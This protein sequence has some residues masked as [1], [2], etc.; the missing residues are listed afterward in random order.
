MQTTRRH[1]A[2]LAAATLLAPRVLRAAPPPARGGVRRLADSPELGAAYPGWKPGELDI[3]FIHTGIGENAFY[4]FPDGTRVVNDCGD[5]WRKNILPQTPSGDRLAAEWVARYIRRL[6]G[7]DRRIDYMLVSHWHG[8]HVGDVRQLARRGGVQPRRLPSGRK[9]CGLAFLGDEFAFGQCLDHQHPRDGLYGDAYC[10]DV[11]NTFLESFIREKGVPRVAFRVGA[12][13]QI[14][15]LHDPD[16]R[17]D[18]VFSVRNICANGVLWDGR[19][20]AEDFA[21]VHARVTGAKTL[22]QNQLS[23]AVRIDYGPFSFFTG[24]DVCGRFKDAAGNWINYEELVGRRTGPVDVCKANH[25]ASRDAMCPAF[26]RQVRAS[27]Y[28][29]NVWDPGHGWDAVPGRMTSQAVCPG[30]RLVC[31]TVMTDRLR[32][33][34]PD[35][36]PPEISPGGHTVVK[37]APGGTSYKVYILETADESMRVNAL[38]E[39]PAAS[40]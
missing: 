18:G 35:G 17:Y 5:F 13:N 1:F 39:R 28:L 10:R 8:D 29:N 30:A 26:L 15:L 36:L 6:I 14:R 37:V 38:Y 4:I 21:A 19:D 25:H 11:M 33:C 16:G 27:V 3:H 23:M 7:N 2:R 9:A 24:G 40:V 22:D 12:K 20:G 32:R 31:P 34:C